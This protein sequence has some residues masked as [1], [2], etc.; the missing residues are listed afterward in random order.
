MVA[1]TITHLIITIIKVIRNT[2]LKCI[3]EIIKV[4]FYLVVTMS[5]SHAKTYTPL[6]IAT[7]TSLQLVLTSQVVSMGRLSHPLLQVQSGWVVDWLQKMFFLYGVGVF[8][9]ICI[10]VQINVVYVFQSQ[11]LIK[12]IQ[13]KIWLY[14]HICMYFFITNQ[15]RRMF[16]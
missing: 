10:D 12:F 7:T 6:Q 14:V 5:H 11:I 13:L 16:E 8:V 4:Q 9:Q 3:N 2:I 1:I 15:Q